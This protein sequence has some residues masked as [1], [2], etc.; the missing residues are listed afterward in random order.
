ML[1]SFA[2]AGAIVVAAHANAKPRRMFAICN[3]LG[4]PAIIFPKG[5][6]ATTRSHRISKC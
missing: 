2:R 5:A 3:N 4:L 6:A 1:P